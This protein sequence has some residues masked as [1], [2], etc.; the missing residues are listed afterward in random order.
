MNKGILSNGLGND[1]ISESKEEH[2]SKF[3]GE[4][5]KDLKE[6]LFDH[7]SAAADK[8]IISSDD[9]IHREGGNR[10]QEAKYTALLSVIADAG[11]GEEYRQYCE[12]RFAK[13][14]SS[15]A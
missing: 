13:C 2:K 11:L 5:L 1:I 7:C 15:S 9:L 10:E 3:G 14:P 8:A 4:I 6:V 12:R